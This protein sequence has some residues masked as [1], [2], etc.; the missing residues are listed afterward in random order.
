MILN[1]MNFI[2]IE[3]PRGENSILKIIKLWNF[4]VN[5]VVHRHLVMSADYFQDKTIIDPT[6]TSVERY[7]FL[8]NEDPEDPKQLWCKFGELR[9]FCKIRHAWA[10]TIHTFQVS[11]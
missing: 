11:G 8:S 6:S 4:E 7:I 9:K 10:R 2:L 3:F 5:D 1:F